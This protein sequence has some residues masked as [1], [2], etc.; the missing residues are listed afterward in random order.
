MIK[1]DPRYSKF[2]SSDRVRRKVF[3]NTMMKELSNKYN[4]ILRIWITFVRFVLMVNIT[5][6]FKIIIQSLLLL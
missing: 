1:E 4:F 6:T 3:L 5:Q 2:S